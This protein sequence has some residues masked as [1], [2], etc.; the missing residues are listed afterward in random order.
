MYTTPVQNIAQK[1]AY[2][3]QKATVFCMLWRHARNVICGRG[4]IHYYGFTPTLLFTFQ[5]SYL[6]YKTHAWH[7]IF[8]RNPQQQCTHTKGHCYRTGKQ[9][10]TCC[11]QFWN[12][13]LRLKSSS[14]GF[15]DRN[16]WTLTQTT[17]TSAQLATCVFVCSLICAC[18]A[19]CL[20]Q[21][22]LLDNRFVDITDREGSTTKRICIFTWS[23]MLYTICVYITQP[24]R[25]CI[26]HGE[27]LD[28]KWSIFSICTRVP[29]Y[30]HARH[31]IRFSTV[32]SGFFSFLLRRS[33]ALGR[34]VA[35]FQSGK[36]HQHVFLFFYHLFRGI[37]FIGMSLRW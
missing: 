16:L 19:V 15:V 11:R 31:V 29:L 26:R 22:L 37:C 36:V 24:C 25:L 18:V 35:V 20:A 17:P 34:P 12:S 28:S 27:A 30:T 8:I 33:G 10:S 32:P 2:I 23:I 5:N 4:E 14:S 1:E 7:W 6:T 21:K 3:A 9:Y 13:M